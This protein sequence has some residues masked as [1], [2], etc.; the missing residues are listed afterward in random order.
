MALARKIP[1]IMK[2]PTNYCAGC[3][4]GIFNR[5]IA[6]VIE[7]K[8]LAKN[9]IMV[10]GVGC[11]CNMNET[12]RGD[13]LQ[14]AHGRAGSV[15]RG[16][17]YGRPESLIMTYQGDGDAYVIGLSD[18]LNPAYMKANITVFVVNNF[19]YAMTGGQMSW[20]TIPEQVTTTSVHGRSCESTG[21]PIRIPEIIADNFEAAY[22]ARGSLH[23][24]K[25][26][27]KTKKYVK[28]AIEAQL[29]H[30]GYSLVEA[31]GQCPTNWS[32]STQ[33]ANEWLEN[34]VVSYYPLG[35]FKK[36]KGG[37]Q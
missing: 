20:T 31:L 1:D 18:T 8:G 4:H 2:K 32:V 15:A 12:W 14:C 16:V 25:E 33:K 19:N 21:K 26:I 37:D 10:L 6:E 11:N 29:N 9:N 23:N 22:V 24:A 36:R 17:K 13:V 30:E 35:E 34:N 5:L 28:N 3:G 7:E 27:N